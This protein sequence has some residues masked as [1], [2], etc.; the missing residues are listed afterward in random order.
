MAT[1]NTEIKITSLPNI[2]NAI[3]P[4]TLIPVVNMAGAP[5]TQKANLQITGNL[6][7]AGA[8]GANFVPARLAN[9][10]YSVVNAAQP[11]ITSTGTL[12]VNTL[13][14]SGGINGQYLQT[15][16]TGNLAWVS[17][18]GSGNGEVGGSNTQIQFNNAGNFGGSSGLTWNGS[19]GLLSTLQLSVA[20]DATIY[21]NTALTNL[22]VA[23][24]LT[25]NNIFTDNYYYANG[26]PFSGG[27]GN[28]TPGG[29]NTQIQ[30]NDAGNFNGNT[31][32]TFNKTTG[33][34]TSPFLVGNG[35]GL[36]NI[37]GANVSGFVPNANVANTAFA[38]A[39]ANVSGFVPNANVANT[40]FAVAAANVS[41]LGNIATINLTGSNSNVLY[42]NG[43]F[44]AV[45]GDNTDWANI[46]N[47][48][49]V[50]GPTKVAV[51][52]NAGNVTQGYS[53]VA[54]GANAGETSQGNSAV[55]IG[56]YTG[57]TNQG[58]YAVAVGRGAGYTAQGANAVA[59][60]RLAG[61]TNQAN[62]SIILNATGAQLDQT[63][64]NTFTVKP[65]RQANTANAMYYDASTG[66]ITYDTAGGGANTG[67]VTFNDVN[68]IGTGNL[69]LQP[70][71]ANASAY[72]DI[73]LTG[74]PDI[75]IAGNGE[76]VILGTDDFANVA[77]NVNGNVSIQAGNVS[78]TQTWN[79]GTDGTTT[80]PSGAGFGLG[81][82]GQLKAN[83]TTTISLDLR[84]SSGRGF[85]T[86]NDG[87]S[88][89]G[90]GDSTW[91]FGTD[92][93]TRFPT[94]NID[95][96]NGGVQSG[97]V[98][99]FGSNQQSI[100]T[101]PTPSANVSAQ[102]I[103]IQGQRGNGT[104]EGGDVYVW[105]GD[106][107]TNG[108]DIKIYAGDADN[109]STGS[110]GYINLAGGDGF[111]SGGGINID[112]GSSANATGGH[113]SIAGGYGQ[114][115]GGTA[116]L[117]GGYGADGQGGAVQITGGGSSNGTGSFGN[118]VLG[119]GV[120]GWI[121]DNTGNLTLPAN[122]FAVN[123]A[124]GTQVS[125]GGGGNTDW[126]NIGNI[127]NASGPTQIAIGAYAGLTTQ[128]TQAVAIG[129]NA[130][131]TTQGN[132]SVAIGPGAGANTQGTEAVAIGTGA[133]ETTQGNSAVAVGYNAGL[134]SQGNN[135]VAV[136]VN[137]GQTAQGIN[138][139]A[140]GYL[141][142]N[143]SQG[144]YTV[145][146]GN[147][148][149]QTSQGPESIAIGSTAG[150]TTQGSFSV[151]VGLNAGRT[152]QGST[153]VALGYNAGLTSQG[154]SAVAIGYF[155]GYTN[156]A[157]NSIILN[158]TGAQLNQTTAN[159]F[160]VKPVRDGGSAAGMAAAG[161]RPVYYNPTTGEFVYASS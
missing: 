40:A 24:N 93:T 57:T 92:G 1:A 76:T 11:N 2:G 140:I 131:V 79:F 10:A 151:A 109:V 128:G 150:Q 27:G 153:A 38:V 42:G 44:A 101:G 36:S 22:N 13:K 122:T 61:Y 159:T 125:I 102:R 87:F 158:A 103:I 50:N 143:S 62:N 37:Q 142:G 23:G 16:G 56:E 133:G 107:D 130:G 124:N 146:I 134:T 106:A 120:S 85:Y 138:A 5:V 63:T 52:Q 4:S 135:S 31:G 74:G 60:G 147:S 73:Y 65:V 47:I 17:G 59:I 69:H 25:T 43:V 77:V 21:G 55:A 118:V 126:A 9:L 30:F 67:N 116:S 66:E 3:A 84:D 51:G 33:I 75:H 160:T 41:G 49:N 88:L 32:F 14:V 91:L 112:G 15:D 141:A 64:A 46:G 100:I 89:R 127:N 129:I 94:A 156:Q 78:G 123:Y 81:E 82:S 96:L 18:G 70:D 132:N 8:G 149:G 144:L 95:L 28:G 19:T 90:D 157:T 98:L 148:A 137:A 68:I 161:F 136:G 104:G 6:I 35:N 7:L 155:A 72:L 45:A 80:F 97:E 154:Q 20:T 12:N 105:A 34:F 58:D 113:V 108:G 83:D 117:Q 26:D 54:I 48:N 71:S 99:Q 139:V 111:D 86:N 119:S 39:G 53:A 145:A 115:D 121:F 29:S 110:G 114:I 152:T